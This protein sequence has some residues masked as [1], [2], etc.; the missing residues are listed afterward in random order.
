MG[1][2][3]TGPANFQTITSSGTQVSDIGLEHLKGLT[4]L[5]VLYLDDTQIT[6]AG[7]EHIKG[8]TQLELLNLQ[9]TNQIT[10]EGVK[11]FHQALPKCSIRQ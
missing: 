10:D 8:L 7:L 11:K 1:C 5:E 4:Q 2:I 3:R 6:D 9:V